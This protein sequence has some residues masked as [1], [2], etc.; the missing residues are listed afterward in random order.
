MIYIREHI[1][2]VIQLIVE[3]VSPIRLFEDCLNE[4]WGLFWSAYHRIVS[5]T[6]LN[7]TRKQSAFKFQINDFYALSSSSEKKN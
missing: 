5:A 2:V 1:N 6:I 7:V 4:H 3:E